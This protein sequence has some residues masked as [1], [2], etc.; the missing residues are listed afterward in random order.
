LPSILH[1]NSDVLLWLKR[2]IPFFYMDL[3]T[4]TVDKLLTP[5]IISN[6]Q[7]V[8]SEKTAAIESRFDKYTVV[9]PGTEE[10][11]STNGGQI[12]QRAFRCEVINSLDMSNF[13]T[14]VSCPTQIEVMITQR[15][16]TY[17]CVSTTISIRIR[18]SSP[19]PSC[20]NF[21]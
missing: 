16:P 2:N 11:N 12:S 7:Q 17:S 21:I 10:I 19:A 5:I 15:R 4:L 1:S 9:F 20:N 13:V 18:F 14:F 8:E 3:H 6:S